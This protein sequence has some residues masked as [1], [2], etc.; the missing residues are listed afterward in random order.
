[1]RLPQGSAING[2]VTE[3]VIEVPIALGPRI[4]LISPNLPREEDVARAEAKVKGNPKARAMELAGALAKVRTI[5]ARMAL[6]PEK[7]TTEAIVPSVRLDGSQLSG[8]AT[9]PSL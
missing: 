9:I 6:S 1:M 2:E 8:L 3:A 5:R 4:T 7:G